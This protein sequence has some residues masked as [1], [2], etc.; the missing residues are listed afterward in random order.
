MTTAVQP[1]FDPFDPDH[2]ADPFPAYRELLERLR[3][4]I[5]ELVDGILDELAGEREVALMPTLAYPLPVIVICQLLGVPAEDRALFG[6]WSSDASRLLDGEVDLETANRG[7]LAVMQLINYL[8]GLIEERRR[9]PQ[10]H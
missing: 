5:Q 10:G 1:G 8:N 9:G 7:V 2:R 4:R 6:P 3:P